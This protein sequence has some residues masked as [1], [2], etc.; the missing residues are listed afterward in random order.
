MNEFCCCKEE[1]E[2]LEI[3]MKKAKDLIRRKLEK[4]TNQDLIEDREF[5]EIV[6]QRFAALKLPLREGE[7]NNT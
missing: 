1:T 7:Y 5:R 6:F 4:T 3:K 2:I